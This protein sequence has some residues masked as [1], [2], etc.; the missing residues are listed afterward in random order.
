MI[1][2]LKEQFLFH[3]FL[4]KI[5]TDFFLNI[6]YFNLISSFVSPKIFIIFIVLGDSKFI[7]SMIN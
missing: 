6:V 2:I 4:Q 7:Y 1:Y 3:D 5:V